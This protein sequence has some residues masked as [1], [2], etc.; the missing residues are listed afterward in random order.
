MGVSITMHEGLGHTW[1][2][3]LVK[4]SFESLYESKI[5]FL[6]CMNKEIRSIVE[7]S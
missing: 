3:V 5:N 2:K 1:S 4:I 7:I 6:G